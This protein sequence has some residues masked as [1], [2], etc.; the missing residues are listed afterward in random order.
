MKV[1]I[2]HDVDHLYP[3]DHIFRD[4]ILP[5][6]YIRSLLHFI[7][8]KI[9]IISLFYRIISIFD[10]RINRIV[11]V[12][13]FDKKNN[14]PSVFFFGMNNIL[15]MSYKKAKSLKYIN[16][17]KENFFD[18]GVHGVDYK[19]IENM[20]REYDDFMMLAKIENFGIRMHY[21]RFDNDTF[22]K[23]S[24]VGYAFDSTYFNKQKLEFKQPYKIGDMWEM[25]LYI[26][27]GY[28]IQIG[29]VEETRKCTLQA[30][31]MAKKENVKYLTILFH[32]YLYNEKCYPEEKNWY[33]WLIKYF[34]DNN[35]KFISYRDAIKEMEEELDFA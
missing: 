15:G 8:G 34:N 4:L 9:N 3:S 31:E 5:K 2:S 6:L 14:I 33:E 24:R 23:I 26:M 11:E 17:L 28:I 7:C 21:V 1:I 29:K 16:M 27:D 22:E 12:M 30:I 32:D 10:S 18:I 19:N 13:N 20:K 25:P 35:Y